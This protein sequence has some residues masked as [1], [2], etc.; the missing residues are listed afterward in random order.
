MGLK[1]K[2]FICCGGIYRTKLF[3]A[4]SG[5]EL[6]YRFDDASPLEILEFTETKI[7]EEWYPL[8]TREA[9]NNF[10]VDPLNYAPPLFVL[11]E[12]RAAVQH[13]NY[14]FLEKWNGI[15]VPARFE[16]SWTDS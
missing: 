16:P 9:I 14:G 15:K 13:V 6:L 3:P 7:E 5:L 10:V 11:K 12:L 1:V 4:V 2:S 8:N